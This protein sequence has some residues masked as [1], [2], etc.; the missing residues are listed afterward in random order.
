MS[1]H[2]ICFCGDNRKIQKLFGQKKSA[3]SRTMTKDIYGKCCQRQLTVWQQSMHH[4]RETKRGI[5]SCRTN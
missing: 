4:S 1:T 5:L 2:N 3:L